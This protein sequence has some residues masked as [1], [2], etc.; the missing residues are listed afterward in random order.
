MFL[1]II[2]FMFIYSRYKSNV[3]NVTAYICFFSY[4]LLTI[5]SFEKRFK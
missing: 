1:Y 4:I 2:G 3:A 5:H